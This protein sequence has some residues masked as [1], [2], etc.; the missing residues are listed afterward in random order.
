MTVGRFLAGAIE[1]SA[2]REVTTR[3][4]RLSAACALRFDDTGETIGKDQSAGVV[5]AGNA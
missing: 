4:V 2:E 5:W 1:N 3:G